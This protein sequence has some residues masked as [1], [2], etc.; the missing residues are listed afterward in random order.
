MS[1]GP[2]RFPS[3]P[4]PRSS[5]SLPILGPFVLPRLPGR[6]RICYIPRSA[7][8]GTAG[9]GPRRIA[10]A[11][12]KTP[13]RLA[14]PRRLDLALLPTPLER[15]GRLSERLGVEVWLKRD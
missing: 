10:V 3:P 11:H 1:R 9:S 13:P 12:P 8:R 7:H 14:F 2:E 4:G 5:P 15:L 6:A